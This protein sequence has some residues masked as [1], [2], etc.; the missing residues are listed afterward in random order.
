MNKTTALLTGFFL[1]ATAVGFASTSGCELVAAVDKSLLNDAGTGG[2][3]GMTTSGSTSSTST[4]STSTSSTSTSSTVMCGDGGSMCTMDSDCHTEVTTKC[5]VATCTTDCCAVGNAASGATCNDNGGT[6]CDG[7]GAC[8]ACVKDSDCGTDTTCQ[9]FT[10]NTSTHTC[11][12]PSNTTKGATCTGADGGT[13]DVCD[14]NG[15]CSASHCTDGVKDSD[16]SD[17][18]CGG[19]CS[20]KCADFQK[21]NSGTD[22]T[23]KVCS[24]ADGGEG[25]CAAPTCGDHVQNGNETDVDCGGTA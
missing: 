11:N 16:E 23:N 20:T 15:N 18:D 10:C 24:G 17:V 14:G 9:K 1:S 13:G 2:T 4:S 7:N 22:C 12:A 6:V 25:T 21:C 19:S 3:G 5:V 8:V